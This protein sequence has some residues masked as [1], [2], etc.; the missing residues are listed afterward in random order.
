M[1]LITVSL[2]GC[3]DDPGT[4]ILMK[5]K[6]LSFSIASQQIQENA[7]GGEILVEISRAQSSDVQVNYSVVNNG[8]IAGV[9]YNILSP[10]PII[11]PAGEY[12]AVIEYEVIDNDFPDEG[13]R[14]FSVEITSLSATGVSIG[15]L[16][17]FSVTIINDDCDVPGLVGEYTVINRDASPAACGDPANDGVLTYDAIITLVSTDG[18]DSYTYEVTDITGGLYALCYG[19]G[20]NPGEFTTVNYDIT[21]TDQPDVIYGGD[22]FNGTGRIE[23]DRSFSIT[24]SNGFGDQATSYY[25]PKD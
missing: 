8:A 22:V 1:S 11:I 15:P 3:F 19:D 6:I 25:T 21:V 20:E 2:S 16:T 17:T 10:N 7:G 13:T 4:D 12:S 14:Q 24:W 23:C 18:V 9:D 5:E